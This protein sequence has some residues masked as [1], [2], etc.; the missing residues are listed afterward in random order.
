MYADGTSICTSAMSKRTGS[1]DRREHNTA[2]GGNA[3]ELA[4][5]GTKVTFLASCQKRAALKNK[6]KTYILG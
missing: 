5:S 3:Q 2:N 1:K 6:G 4:C